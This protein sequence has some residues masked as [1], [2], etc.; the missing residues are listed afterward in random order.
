MGAGSGSISK[1]AGAH[2]SEQQPQGNAGQPADYS[3]F[4]PPGAD[5][6]GQ[7]PA[8]RGASE[9]LP[10]GKAPEPVPEVA[11]SWSRTVAPVDS[12]VA[13]ARSTKNQPR[14][15]WR[16]FRYFRTGIASLCAVLVVLFSASAALM[17][18]VWNT[19]VD[20][21]NYMDAATA[22]FE[23]S[24]VPA[25]IADSIVAALWDQH[26]PEEIAEQ[27]GQELISPDAGD[28]LPE[29][30]EP[31]MWQFN[32]PQTL[33]KLV[34]EWVPPY[35]ET[36]VKSDEGKSLW[37]EANKVAHANLLDRFEGEASNSTSPLL[38]LDSFKE[39]WA[40]QSTGIGFVDDIISS[41]ELK[42][43]FVDAQ[44]VDSLHDAY[45]TGKTLRILLP[46]CALVA[47]VAGL[48]T[49]RK[50]GVFLAVVGAGLL[51]AFAA[52]SQIASEVSSRLS[53]HANQDL[54]GVVLKEVISGAPH[55]VVDAF[56]LLA[57]V[58]AI[59]L[60]AGLALIVLPKIINKRVKQ[61]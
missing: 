21:D 25:M 54:G 14:T 1:D 23:D 35:I 44:T 47:L 26:P 51:I 6:S 9:P 58:G 42:F 33:V 49:A 24:K 4:A 17:G 10:E 43:A 31:Y 59:L 27:L 7:L 38:N 45:S 13:D 61:A 60:A 30:F 5:V 3:R 34:E 40:G 22:A 20:Q 37:N 53:L 8:E 11:P 18:G 56:Q 57:I 12:Q 39:L 41:L 2:V 46:V 16:G 55:H 28:R 36:L 48:A 15:P 32:D 50:R 52:R 19:F 29:E